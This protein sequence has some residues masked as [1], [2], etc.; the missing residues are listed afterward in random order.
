MAFFGLLCDIPRD[1]KDSRPLSL[2]LIVVLYKRVVHRHHRVFESNECDLNNFSQK[3][4][5]IKLLQYFLC[6][7]SQYGEVYSRILHSSP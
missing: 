6:T 2:R 4:I 3:K 5:I 1:I 7:E